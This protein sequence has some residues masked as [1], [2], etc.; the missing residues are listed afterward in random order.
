FD[1][2]SYCSAMP[3]MIQPSLQSGERYHI[4]NAIPGHRSAARGSAADRNKCAVTNLESGEF[5]TASECHPHISTPGRISRGLRG[6]R[7]RA[8]RNGG[9]VAAQDQ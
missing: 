7:E 2:G 6:Q 4:T 5:H 1:E 9:I 3:D 8:F